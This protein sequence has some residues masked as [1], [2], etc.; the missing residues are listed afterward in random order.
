MALNHRTDKSKWFINLLEISPIQIYALNLKN[1]QQH[2]DKFLFKTIRRCHIIQWFTDCLIVRLDQTICFVIS[3]L[4][5]SIKSIEILKSLII[6]SKVIWL[7][8]SNLLDDE[9]HNLPYLTPC[10]MDNGNAVILT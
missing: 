10:L 6:I 8:N 4:L 7:N 5:L 9:T 3:I 1:G 2:S